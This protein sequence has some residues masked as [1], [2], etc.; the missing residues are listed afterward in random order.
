MGTTHRSLAAIA[1]IIFGAAALSGCTSAEA[2]ATQPTV[3]PSSAS[4]FASAS[5][6]A[7]D[8]PGSAIIF[9]V[10]KKQIGPKTSTPGT[11][12]KHYSGTGP[13]TL[14]IPP[15]APGQKRLG[16]IVIC[17]GAGEWKVSFAR[18]GWSSGV[19]STENSSTA[20]YELPAPSKDTA[21]TIDVPADAN[22]WLTVFSTK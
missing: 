17:S 21:V 2:T 15:L 18:V 20:I 1:A 6:P 10:Q 9:E 11:V 12:V 4:S 8:L 16:S 7:K 22:V 3:T 14:H 5:A 13:T 19:C